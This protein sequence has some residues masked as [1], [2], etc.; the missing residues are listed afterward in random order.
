MSPIQKFFSL[1]SIGDRKEDCW[2]WMGSSLPKGYGRFYA[3][4]KMNYAH[5]FAYETWV[6]QIPDGHFIC[7]H[8]DNPSCCNPDHLFAGTQKDNMRD[9]AEKGRVHITLGRWAG[10]KNPKSKLTNESRFAIEA[11]LKNGDRPTYVA[12]RFGISKVRA[13]QIR[14]EIGLA[15]CPKGRPKGSKNRNGFQGI[16]QCGK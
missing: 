13:S 15:P 9:C 7:H 8:C 5:R 4:G 6:G 14:Q 2:L 1:V 12:E 11:A 10:I 3:N 16:A